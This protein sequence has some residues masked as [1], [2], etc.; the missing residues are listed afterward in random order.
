MSDN[1]GQAALELRDLLARR[2]EDL[3]RQIDGLRSE[4]NSS[5]ASRPSAHF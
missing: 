5:R 4:L 3:Q 2:R 1:S